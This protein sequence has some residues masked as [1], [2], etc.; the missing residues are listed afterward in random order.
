MNASIGTHDN[1]IASASAASVQRLSAV[2]T[3][4]CMVFAL[5]HLYWAAGGEAGTL[6]GVAA[7]TRPVVRARSG[8]R[9]V[10]SA[11]PGVSNRVNRRARMVP[12]RG[13]GSAL[14]FKLPYALPPI[15]NSAWVAW[16]CQELLMVATAFWT[17]SCAVVAGRPMSFTR[18]SLVVKNSPRARPASASARAAATSA[19][20][21][22]LV[23]T[24][25]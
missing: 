11:P 18:S 19:G 12:G 1:A 22:A 20:S 17:T 24:A 21:P 14:I 5:V 15:G 4:W 23:R 3:V 10:A 9:S 2:T 8:T 16:R 25:V 7:S 13:A 6:D